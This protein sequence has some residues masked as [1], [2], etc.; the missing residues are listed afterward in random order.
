MET[1]VIKYKAYKYDELSDE[2]KDKALEVMADINVDYDWWDSTVEYIAEEWGNKY[3]IE[4]KPD[5]LCFDLGPHR[6]LYFHGQ[7]SIWVSQP[8]RLAYAATGR[9]GYGLQAAKSILDL[10]FTTHYYGGGDGRT[11]L[12]ITDYRRANAPDLPVDFDDWFRG[13]CGDFFNSLDKEYEY[14]T[15]REAVEETIRINEFDFYEDG[16]R[17][18]CVCA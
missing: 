17:C 14:L 8:Y 9:R 2:A 7:G 12:E 16:R 13:L 11:A 18:K 6:Q 10:G 3:G 1:R 15:S 5:S 4:F